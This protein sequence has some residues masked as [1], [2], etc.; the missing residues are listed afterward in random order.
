MTAFN[1]GRYVAA[2]IDSVL[3]QEYPPELL[4][5]VVVDD[6][7]TDETPE[8]LEAAKARHGARLTAVRQ[9]NAGLARATA[10]ALSH[11]RGELIAIC[12]ADDLW[13]PGKVAAQVE[14]FRTNPEVSLAYADMLVI[15]PEG[16]VTS[17]SFFADQGIEPLR[18]HLLDRLVYKNFVTNSTLMFR[19]ADLRPYPD[20]FPYADY[21]LSS[22]AAAAGITEV[23]EQPLASYRLHGS[24]MDFGATGD[25]YVQVL[26]RELLARRLLISALIESLSPAGLV[27]I[28]NELIAKALWTGTLGTQT[29]EQILEISDADREEAD[30]ELARGVV[31]LDADARLRAFARARALD[32]FNPAAAAAFQ[33]QVASR[34]SDAPVSVSPETAA[35]PTA[36][37]VSLGTAAP[38]AVAVSVDPS[39]P[40]ASVIIPAFNLARYLP[41]AI[42]SALAQQPPGGAVEVIVVDDGSA[43]ETPEVVARYGDRIRSVRQE[44]AGTMAA[45]SHGVSLARGEFLAQLD[46]DD[47]WPPDRLARHI[48][49]LDANPQVGLVQSDMAVTDAEG[50]ITH[51]SFFERERMITPNGRV[52]GNLLAG[53]FVSGGASTYRASLVPAIFPIEE[54]AAYED[55][56]TACCI[57]CVAEIQTVEGIANLY[58]FHG[59]NDS[60]GRAD[61]PVIQRRELNWRRWMFRH[62]L[63][64]DTITVAQLDTA[65]ASFR[66]GLRAA[67][68]DRPGGARSL[69]EPD[70]LTAAADLLELPPV[71]AGGAR[72]RALLR[73]LAADPFDGAVLIDLE[74]A[75][76]QEAQ[77]PQPSPGPPLSVLA[78]RQHLSVAWLD[79]VL[80]N[81]ELL[82]AYGQEADALDRTTLAILSGP[83]ADYS[84]LVEL[85]DSDPRLSDE[86]CEI[87]LINAPVTPPA[88]RLLAHRASSL[89]TAREPD[90]GYESLPLHPAVERAVSA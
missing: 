38:P 43:D 42:E 21:W 28:V 31:E 57:A 41:M 73:A 7:S 37:A 46:A 30:R 3:T 78:S 54:S 34:A 6:E 9:A 13:L 56:W 29:V 16:A 11:A 18:G 83:N 59:A 44:N 53:N 2:A 1:Y 69:L 5:L 62:L 24:N 22:N 89:L 19:A 85:V 10:T 36:V 67:A 47:Q 27:E 71:A 8:V 81:P 35:G 84:R 15:D 33:Q 88:T 49:V 70:P 76:M 26:A 4:D 60:L 14:L 52:L 82:R 75:L 74:L 45:V 50:R 55:W 68:L 72:S 20:R 58:R 48:S 63:D 25:R 79:E 51:P 90:P 40:R 12:D 86:D 87:T 23:I 17:R 77:L 61:Q 32:P 64:D 66:F 39:R 80:A 65:L